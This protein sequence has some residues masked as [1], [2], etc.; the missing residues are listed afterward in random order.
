MKNILEEIKE[1]EKKRE[2]IAKETNI[3]KQEIIQKARRDSIKLISEK[4]AEL[5]KKLNEEIKK[6]TEELDKKKEEIILKSKKEVD[7]L[8]KKSK[9]KVQTAI[10]YITNKFEE[11]LS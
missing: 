4:E 1:A 2:K 10:D 8:E 7:L 6:K 9:S 3:K 11:S 5:D